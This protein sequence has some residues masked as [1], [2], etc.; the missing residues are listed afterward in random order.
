MFALGWVGGLCTGLVGFPWI[1]ET[2]ERFGEF[3]PWLAMIGLLAFSAWTAIPFGFW[4]LGVVAGPRRGAWALVWPVVLWIG[5]YAVWPALFPYTVVIGL[6]M[7]PEWMQAAELGGVPL[8]ETQALIAGIL[9]ADGLLATGRGRWIRLL[10]A[11]AIPAASWGVG[12]LRM[13]QLEEDTAG[14]RTVRF[15]LVQPN[16]PLMAGSPFDKMAR[17]WAQS[18][19]A[20]SEGAG[21][22]V[23]PE[24]GAYPFSGPR[25]M[26]RDFEGDPYRRILA[27]HRVPTILGIATQ[28]MGEPY[29]YNSVIAMSAEGRVTGVFDKVNLVPFG[30]YIPVVEPQWAQEFIPAMSHNFAG[31]GPARFEVVPGTPSEAKDA[32]PVHLGPLICYE[33]IFPDFAREVAVQPGGI[34]VF[35]NV[36]IDTWFGDTAEP[37]EHLALAQFRSVEH[38]IP[39]VRSVAA[40]TT[41]V[42]DHLGRL[43]AALPVRDPTVENPVPP[44]RLVHDVVL[45]RNTATSPTIFARFGWTFRWWCVG[46]VALL[47]LA[48]LFRS[49]YRPRADDAP[50]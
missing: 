10:V 43:V 17:L 18:K 49:K 8:V 35:V 28:A 39:M 19:A 38:R 2:L 5:L 6:A 31:T 24:A 22:V 41:S 9:L 3:P 23:W 29:Q 47:G 36:T 21:I 42:V 15:G 20:Q 14:A 4:A 44:E 34:E 25:P 27:H 45:P 50:E 12:S 40:G 48:R 32:E 37:W 7:T 46:A 11:L 1:A 33:D 16:V 26:T 30:E 13:Q